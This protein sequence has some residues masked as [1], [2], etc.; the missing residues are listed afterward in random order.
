MLKSKLIAATLMLFTLGA[1][2]ELYT[3]TQSEAFAG[4]AGNKSSEPGVDP[5][6][7]SKFDT[8][9]GNLT[10]VYVRYDF[11]ILNG[12]IGADNMTNDEAA[13]SGV[14]GAA[15]TF[16]ASVPFLDYTTTQPVLTN[17]DLTQTADFTLA[18]DP[19]MSVGGSGPDVATM[20]GQTMT[21][22][23]GWVRLTDFFLGDFEGAGDTFTINFDTFSNLNVEVAGAQGF[24]QVVDTEIN[25]DVYYAYEE[26]VE[27]PVE[28]PSDVSAPLTALAG[29]SLLGLAGLRRKR[30]Q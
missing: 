2:A 17:V 14:L 16:T 5:F 19:T 30:N 9:L 18:A 11:T 28:P 24:F 4:T 1:N 7:F 23:S 10:G 27:P 12:L 3:P 22:D 25:F 29:L 6:V 21:Q 15:A 26:I 8:A 20:Y 13:G